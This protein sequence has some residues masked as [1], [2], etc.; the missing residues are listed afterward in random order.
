MFTITEDK[1]NRTVTIHDKFD[2][3][4]TASEPDATPYLNKLGDEYILS[5]TNLEYI[6][7]FDT[8]TFEVSG[9]SETRLTKQYYRISRDNYRW[10]DWLDLN[11]EITNFPLTDPLDPLFIDIKWVRTGTNKLGT[12][13]V[14][15]YSLNGTLDTN[16][17]DDDSVINLPS[18][19]SILVKPPYIYKVFKINDIEIISSTGYAD[20]EILYRYSQDN[21]RTWSEWEPL[22]GENISTTRITPI[23]FFQIQY[24]VT[25]NSNSTVKIQDINLIGNFQ[26]VTLD[27]KKSNLYGVR[28][29]CQSNLNGSYDENG[30]FIPN[31][32]LNSSSTGSSSGSGGGSC[33]GTNIFTPMTADQS[34]QL[35]N[36]YS[37]NAATNLLNKLTNDAQQMFG[38]TVIYFVTD[39]DAK[40][41][42]FSLHEYSLY[43]VVC[44]E[45][46]KITVENN[47]FPDSQITFN[48]FDLNLFESMEVQITKE[49]FKQKFGVQRRPSKEDIIYFCNLNRLFQV[50]HAQQFRSF[51]NTAVFYKLILKK[52]NQ[53]SNVQAG[54]SDIKNQLDMLT[55]NTTIEQL[56]GKDIEMDKEAIANKQQ[57]T[58]LTKDPIRLEYNAIINKELIENSST[59][60]SKSNY[61]LSTVSFGETAVEYV[62]LKSVLKVS[63]NIGF[64]CWFNINNYIIDE[65]YNLFDYY[66]STDN[67]G[68][69]ANLK[70]DRISIKLNGDEYSFDL[71]GTNDV[72]ALDEETWYGYI[73]NIDQRQRKISQYVYKRNVDFEEDA[74]RLSSTVLRQVYSNTQNM[75]PV[76]YEIENIN[77]AVLGCDMRMTNI[78]L[79]DDVIPVETH[80]K[81]LNEYIIR[82]DS[83]YLVFGDNATNKLSLPNYPLHD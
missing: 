82:D 27:Y 36:P 49:M 54:N 22:T 37:Q 2:I 34:A 32:N 61:D 50:D 42:D 11:E 62:N 59:I 13:R 57:H 19:G 5:F 69:N 39:P 46:L 24:Y 26:N 30:N 40:G 75:T 15:E 78:R 44:N 4:A 23:R 67:I 79:F 35:Y 53:K 9:T 55:Q 81:I 20:T 12:I 76:D 25:N 80:N 28:E 66:D 7:S 29:C 10:G 3:S 31:T 65:V 6:H 68:W 64:T 63:D 14:L 72:L 77:P 74:S 16:V 48:Q 71:L 38:H 33:D 60:V 47:N 45:E 8:F 1:L 17:N 73:L 21:S 51:N 41:D 83:K 43:N 58:T 52:Y 18:G 70:N 56:F